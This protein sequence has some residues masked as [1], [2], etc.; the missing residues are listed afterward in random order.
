VGLLYYLLVIAY[1]KY[2]LEGLNYFSHYGMVR[3][4]GQPIGLRHTYSSN[5][6]IGNMILLNLGRHGA[7]HVDGKHYQNLKAYP[8]M[9]QAP[10]G[11]LTMTAISWIP[12]LFYKVMLPVIKEWDQKY[13]T[14]V[15]RELAEQQNVESG[16]AALNTGTT[17]A[18]SRMP[19]YAA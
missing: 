3:E 12:P 4:R 7:H 2:I 8:D 10:Y 5:N 16:L 9:P 13:A 18:S 15:E 19:H 1:A 14:P 11:Y 6:A 17:H